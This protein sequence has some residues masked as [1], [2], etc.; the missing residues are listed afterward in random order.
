MSEKS[1]ED[2]IN[3]VL[4][5]DALINALNFMKYLQANEMIYDGHEIS[6]KDKEVCYMHIGGAERPGP[7]TIWIEG[8]DY[9]GEREDVPIDEHTKKIA[10]ANINP[11]EKCSG[12]NPET[13][14]TIFGKKF[15]NLCNAE[16][17]FY[18]PDTEKIECVKKLIEMRK[19]EILNSI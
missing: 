9:S 1:F 6:Y 18:I 4:S 8:G 17:A 11:C 10:W 7:W 15:D 16:M 12:C 3:D 14:K 13:P 2:I 19:R 5:G